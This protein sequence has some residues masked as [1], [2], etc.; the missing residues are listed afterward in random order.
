MSKYTGS[1]G[2][3]DRKEKEKKVCDY[4]GPSPKFALLKHKNFMS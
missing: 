3:V 1:E 2:N 4:T